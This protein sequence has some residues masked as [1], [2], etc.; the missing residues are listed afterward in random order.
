MLSQAMAD[1]GYAPGCEAYET[2]VVARPS[3][4]IRRIEQALTE[5]A[6]KKARCL[7]DTGPCIQDE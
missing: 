7:S 3:A 1:P 5:R 4:I 2:S 6:Q